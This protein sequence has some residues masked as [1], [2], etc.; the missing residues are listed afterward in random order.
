MSSSKN[1]LGDKKI[2]GQEAKAAAGAALR[3]DTTTFGAF[4][5]WPSYKAISLYCAAVTSLRAATNK[6]GAKETHLRVGINLIE[7]GSRRA[8]PKADLAICCTAP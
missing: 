3:E 8:V 6:Y 7:Q 5:A 4:L 1:N 2:A